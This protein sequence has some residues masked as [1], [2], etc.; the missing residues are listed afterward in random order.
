MC[1][2]NVKSGREIRY[3]RER[4]GIARMWDAAKKEGV[5]RERNVATGRNIARQRIV[6]PVLFSQEKK[7]KRMYLPTTGRASRSA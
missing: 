1:R 3:I 7:K 5:A 4:G 2:Q 6:L